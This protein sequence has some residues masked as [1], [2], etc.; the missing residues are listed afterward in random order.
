MADPLILHGR[1]VT[2]DPARPEIADG[3]LY[4]DD[5]GMIAGVKKATDAAPPGFASAR[6]VHTRGN[7]YPG[8]IDLHNHIAY[9]ILPLWSPPGRSEPYTS[10]YQ[11]PGDSSY[12]G[13]IS[14]PAN[15]LGALAGKAH[16]KYVETKAAVGGVTAIQG[17]A[18]MAY[19]Y[20]G[21]LV[22]NIENETFK[23]GK[24]TVYQSALPLQKEADYARDRERMKAGAAFI[25]HVSE[26]TDPKLVAEYDK[27]R[28]EDCLAPRFCGIHCTA[29]QAPNYNEW[30]ARGGSVVWSPFSNL[31]LYRR[32]TDVAAAKAAGMRICLGADWAPSGSKNLLGELKVA[33]MWNRDHLGRVFSDEELCAMTTRNPAAALGWDDRIGRLEE[34]L[35]ADVVVT[36]DRGGNA[37]R[38]LIE[39]RERDIE[40]VA[41]NGQPFYGTTDLMSAAGAAG[42]EPIRVG[43]LW[44]KVALVYPGVPDA[45]M[46]WKQVL[47]DI[48]EATADP[49]ARY[50][51]IEHLHE[52]GKP[53]PWLKTDKLWDNPDITHKEVD[54]TV[55]IPPLDPLFH[56]RS[57]FEAI[58][59]SPIHGGLLDRLHEYYV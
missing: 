32:T 41:I 15:A 46:T 17:S 43:R 45:D 25:Y 8:L 47:A 56:D 42:A 4:I 18:K 59:K 7:V 35:H 14:D 5:D 52:V 26:G 57:Y 38:N 27:L 51:R 34:G 54:V 40:L 13:W 44:R 58:A 9:N 22:R 36:N 19:P 30:H 53:P 31:W 23:T 16:L 50:L 21:W 48:A 11:W 1:L 2:F 3:A 55:R 24:K 20:E 6:R 29:L 28:D 37:Y 39:S 49:I 10:R 33:D 12:E